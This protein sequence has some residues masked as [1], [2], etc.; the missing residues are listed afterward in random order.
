MLIIRFECSVSLTSCW[1][2]EIN[3]KSVV[4]NM[5]SVGDQRQTSVRST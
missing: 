2:C 5:R 1:R 3:V 4:I